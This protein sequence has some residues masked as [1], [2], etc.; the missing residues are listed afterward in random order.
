MGPI[1]QSRPVNADVDFTA[2]PLRRRQHV[3]GF[4]LFEVLVSILILAVGMLA[5]AG[6]QLSAIRT[7]QQSSMQTLAMSLAADMA[8]RMRANDVIMNAPDAT[9]PFLQVNLQ[10]GQA[11]SEPEK[12]CNLESAACTPTELANFEIY[13]WQKRLRELMPTAQAVICRD[14]NPWD[15]VGKMYKWR[16]TVT[17][18]STDSGPVT[19]KVGWQAKKPDGTLLRQSNGEF[20]PQVAL[21]VAPSAK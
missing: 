3:Q 16:C 6:L 21:I 4:T 17:S 15:S 13:D 19:I 14:T 9:N 12:F 5:A 2:L 7:T 1:R 8:D 10:S 18:T 11:L 20:P